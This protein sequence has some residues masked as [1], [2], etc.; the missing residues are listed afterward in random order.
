MHL[1]LSLYLSFSLSI[2]I[3]ICMFTY[4]YIYIDREREREIET[5]IVKAKRSPRQERRP[6][7]S[8]SG[9]LGIKAPPPPKLTK[10]KV[11]II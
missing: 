10:P 3:C 6:V 11:D 8:A 1:S 5:Y 4:T 2:Y 7:A 9:I